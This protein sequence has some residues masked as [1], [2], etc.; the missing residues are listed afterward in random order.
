[1]VSVAAPHGK[2]IAA[3]AD[4]TVWTW[5]HNGT[6]TQIP[7]LTD[8]TDV[9]AGDLTGYALRADGTV[10]AWGDGHWGQLGNG[11]D[12]TSGNPPGCYS[13]V[14]V[15][16]LG[17]TDVVALPT[18]YLRLNGYALRADGTAWAWGEREHL[19]APASRD[20][21]TPLRIDLPAGVTS[22]SAAGA[23]VG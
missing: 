4:G 9:A 3:R 19:G 12:C 21:S 14:P 2:G 11:V 10:W 13:D 16:V 7:T 22:L 20:M 15:R 8:V 1:V 23:V 17:L 5:P 6:P 18:G